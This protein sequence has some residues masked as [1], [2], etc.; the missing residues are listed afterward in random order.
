MTQVTNSSAINISK[1][2]EEAALCL[3]YQSKGRFDKK[4]QDGTLL[5]TMT[6]IQH[7]PKFSVKNLSRLSHD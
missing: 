4:P 6:V 2:A 5:L 1:Q 7:E 3:G